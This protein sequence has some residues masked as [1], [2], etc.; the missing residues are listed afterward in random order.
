MS[1]MLQ[2]SSVRWR[3]LRAQVL[4]MVYDS[5]S[6]MWTQTCALASRDCTQP[7]V[8]ASP[9]SSLFSICGGILTDPLAVCLQVRTLQAWAPAE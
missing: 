3:L 6:L 2:S 8:S 7:A 4:D 9:A 5:A 1:Q